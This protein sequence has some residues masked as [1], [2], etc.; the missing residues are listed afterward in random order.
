MSWLEQ[1]DGSRLELFGSGGGATV[2]SSLSKS[3]GSEVPL[4]GQV[5]MDPRVVTQGDAG[6]PIVLSEPEAPAS[7]VL[8]D[9]AK[10]LSVRARGLAGM[11]LN[12]TPAG[13]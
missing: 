4:L 11:M 3:I 7:V 13:R 1:A 12:V 10:K 5:P 6:T 8:S 9:V 2:A